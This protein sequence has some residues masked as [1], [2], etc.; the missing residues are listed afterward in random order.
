M[1]LLAPSNEIIFKISLYI[2]FMVEFALDIKRSSKQ[3][4]NLKSERNISSVESEYYL[5]DWGT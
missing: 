3:N 2:Y 1:M 5:C 4:I